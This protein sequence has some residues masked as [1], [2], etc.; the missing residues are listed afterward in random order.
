M[1]KTH[2]I[3]LKRMAWN[4]TIYNW[5]YAFCGRVIDES[6]LTGDPDKVTCK[7]CLRVIGKKERRHE[8]DTYDR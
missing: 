2:M 8:Q 1:S 3:D 7:N 5:T 4:Y 6:N